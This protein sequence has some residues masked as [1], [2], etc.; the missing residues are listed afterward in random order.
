MASLEWMSSD[1]ITPYYR[2]LQST[3][4]YDFSWTAKL[5][6]LK[7]N[8][9]WKHKFL[10]L[11][12]IHLCLWWTTHKYAFQPKHVDFYHYHR[13]TVQT[14]SPVGWRWDSQYQLSSLALRFLPFCHACFPRKPMFRTVT[15]CYTQNNK[16]TLSVCLFGNDKCQW[17]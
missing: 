2:T 6:F 1:A 16:K 17:W 9:T 15:W 14:E 4:D 3:K 11:Q 5:L 12:E 13:S 8:L 10:H 7:W